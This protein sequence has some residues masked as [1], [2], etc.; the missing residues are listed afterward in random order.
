MSE[1]DEKPDAGH[2][3]NGDGERHDDGLTDRQVEE[4][5]A[6]LEQQFHD[7]KLPEQQFDEELAGVIGNKAKVAVIITRLSSADLLAAFCQLAGI[8]ALCVSAAEGAVAVLR[9]REGDDPEV[10]ARDLT[11][12]VNGL[13]AVLAVNR[14]DKLEVTLWIRGRAGEHF[15][16]PVL[17]TS[18]ARFVEDLLIGAVDMAGLRTQGYTVIDSSDYT[19]D[20][21]LRVIARHTRFGPGRR[22][23]AG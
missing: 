10:A 16:P 1:D 19:R 23:K 17:F 6:G 22:G 14:A 20:T 15:S 18:T 11:T 7:V 12:V 13:S 8:S 2:H 21:A 9:N 3:D 4:T 5:L